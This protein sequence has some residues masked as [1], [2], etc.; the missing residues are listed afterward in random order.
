MGP[1]SCC[2]RRRTKG[3]KPLDLGL[4]LGLTFEE[5]GG[6]WPSSRRLDA[7]VSTPRSRRGHTG[8]G[9]WGSGVAEQMGGGDDA[10]DEAEGTGGPVVR[11]PSSETGNPQWSETKNGGRV[12]HHVVNI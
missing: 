5:P 9:P 6:A 1:K 10:G 8:Q 7:T 4:E 3:L 2:S 12:T 11:R